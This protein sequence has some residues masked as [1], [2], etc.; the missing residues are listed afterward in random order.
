VIIFCGL[1]CIVAF[2]YGVTIE[3][4]RGHNFTVDDIALMVAGPLI[5][6]TGEWFWHKAR[7]KTQKNAVSRKP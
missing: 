7:T 1:Y 4:P 3:I 6:L 5:W 2:I